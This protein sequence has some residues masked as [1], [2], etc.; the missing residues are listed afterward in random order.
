MEERGGKKK[1]RKR[2][3]AACL[4]SHKVAPLQLLPMLL[5]LSPRH[6]RQ[7][8]R[9][10]YLLASLSGR[11]LASDFKRIFNFIQDLPGIVDDKRQPFSGEVQWAADWRSSSPEK[12]KKGRLHQKFKVE[13][14]VC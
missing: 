3:T 2:M 9:L 5:L 10:H 4:P 7:Q 13:V 1:R 11:R 8:A 14:Q 6:P 12:E